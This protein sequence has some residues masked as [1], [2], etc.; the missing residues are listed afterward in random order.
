FLTKQYGAFGAGC[1]WLIYNSLLLCISLPIF[2]HFYL[3]GQFFH[4]IKDCFIMPI[5]I[6]GLIFFGGYI[7]L[8]ERNLNFLEL[9]LSIFIMTIIY[10]GL[11]KEVRSL[12]INGIKSKIF[13]KN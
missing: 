5:L 2:H 7:L 1:C 8:K 6:A 10:G 4:W 13:R 12:F 11:M 3:K 9:G